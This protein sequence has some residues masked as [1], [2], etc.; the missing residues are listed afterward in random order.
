MK[1][2]Y[3]IVGD[4]NFWYNTVTCTE[5]ELKDEIKDVKK[6]IKDGEFND[7]VNTVCEILFV[8]EAKKIQEDVI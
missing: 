6:R 3:L 7:Q 2:T 4:N 8:Y 1:K 5:R